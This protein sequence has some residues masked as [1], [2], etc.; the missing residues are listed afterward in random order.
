MLVIT[1]PSG[2]ADGFR[3]TR[4]SASPR[5]PV[6][7]HQNSSPKGIDLDVRSHLR[8][9]EIEEF[10]VRETNESIDGQGHRGVCDAEISGTTLREFQQNVRD[11]IY[12]TVDDEPKSDGRHDDL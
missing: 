8:L 4:D 10:L 7:S 12:G 1:T 5:A 9:A 6:P 11:H 3:R 2:F